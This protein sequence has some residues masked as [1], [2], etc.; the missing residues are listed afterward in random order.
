MLITIIENNF[1][2]HYKMIRMCIVEFWV[3]NKY[4]IKIKMNIQI[5]LRN[6]C[7]SEYKKVKIILQDQ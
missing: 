1:I 3:T 2:Q 5:A 6:K 7:P 4:S